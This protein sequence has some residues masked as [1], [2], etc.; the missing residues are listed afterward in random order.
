MAL[1]R[2][3]TLTINKKSSVLNK[4]LTISTNDKGIDIIFRLIDC[5][6]V[7][8]SLKKNLYA[9]IILLDPLGK[10]ID[11]DVTSIVENRVLFRLT[12][13]LMS[14]ITEA[15]IYKLYIAIMD[16]KNNVNLLPPVKCTIEESEVTVRGL[17][18]GMTNQSSIDNS[19]STDYGNEIALFNADGTYNRTVWISGDMITTAR[20]NKLEDA[21][22]KAR[23][24]IL[25]IR[26]EIEE[27]D[28][29]RVH[30]VLIGTENENIVISNLPKGF[31]SIS[32]YVRDFIGKD[33][34][35]LDG[36]NYFIVTYMSDEYSKIQRC[37]VKEQKFI[38]YKYDKILETITIN[39]HELVKCEQND[40]YISLSSDENQYCELKVDSEIILPKV[41]DF[42]KINLFIRAVESSVLI[43]DKVTWINS[44]KLRLG[45]LNLITL[46]Y[47]NGTWYGEARTYLDGGYAHIASGSSSSGG[48]SS[49]SNL[50]RKT[51]PVANNSVVLSDVPIQDVTLV[52][53]CVVD[54]PTNYLATHVTLNVLAIN[55]LR[56]SFVQGSNSQIVDLEKDS[57]TK[58]E[59][60]MNGTDSTICRINGGGNP[61]SEEVVKYTIINN[62]SNCVSNNTS[63]NINRGSS[64]KAIITMDSGYELNN[65][66]I[67]MG[68]TNVTT[69]VY[70]YRDS[71]A[72]I[73]ISKVTGDIIVI[74]QATAS[75]EGDYPGEAFYTVTKNLTN[76]SSSNTSSSVTEGASY[77]TS[78]TAYSGCTLGSI[79]VSMNG[80]DITSTVVNGNSINIPNVTGDLVITA[81]AK[82]KIALSRISDMTIY[83]G[84]TF[85]ILYSSNISAVKHEISWDGGDTF[86]DKTSEILVEN[87]VNYKYSHNAETEYDS[88]NMAIR[89]TDAN[90]N[91]DVK[92]FTI[93][94]VN[95]ELEPGETTYTITRNLTNC[96]SSNTSTSV[97]KGSSY[98]T[99]IMA[100]DNSTMDSI[101]VLMKGVD[102]ANGYATP[103]Y[104]KATY[105]ISKNLTNCGSSNTSTSVTEGSGYISKITANNGYTLSSIKVTM[106]GNDVTSSVV[107][108][109]NINIANVTGNIVITAKAESSGFIF[110][111]YKRLDDGVLVDYTDESE[112]TYYATVGMN[113]VEPASNYAIDVNLCSYICVCYYDEYKNYI[114]YTES[115]TDDWSVKQLSTTILTPS[116]AKYIRVCA[117]NS[118]TQVVG[119]LTK[120]INSGFVF[121]KYKRLNDGVLVDYTD[122]SEVT[123][124]ATVN[125]N[126]VMPGSNYI[127]SINT[128][129]YICVCYY[130]ENHNYLTYTEANTDDWSARQFS[131]TIT[132]PSNARYIRV[133]ATNYGTQV[134]GT[135]IKID[136]IGGFTF[137]KYKR[138][139]DGVLIDYTDESE[140]TYHATVNLNEVTP[141]ANYIIKINSC[142]YIY[143]CYYDEKHNYISYTEAHTD[144]WSI[145]QL[146]TTI[147]IPSNAKYIRVCATNNGAQVEGV[148]TQIINGGGVSIEEI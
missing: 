143:V 59:I 72:I 104:G 75:S 127:I 110:T 118:G 71:K 42:T 33:P 85:N 130:D 29:N 47:M 8:L 114:T 16:D 122:E 87:T 137:T 145:K 97:S 135:L 5:P 138:L 109:N 82:P 123:Y 92:Y 108:G 61:E 36:E 86:W 88:F 50:F 68:G 133:C 125:L 142:N 79:T 101:S 126:P 121:T 48:S 95:N 37:L 11:S 40:K 103:I 67:T 117:T 69:S 136:E 65:I 96:S 46:T 18:V 1:K 98:T 21:A 43:F 139:N 30:K 31:Y 115:N 83:K 55:N 120:T 10:Q 90:G 20:M 56:L 106:G 24:S 57:L 76:C 119:T 128:C 94:F 91:T 38:K 89:V 116:N 147:T 26:D 4:N 3:Y 45:E 14:K 105:T 35:K 62:L 25:S 73:N 12:K 34:Y 58:F 140:A 100:N 22:S 77:T 15:G 80:N 84:Q 17:S 39:E 124:Y 99:N 74:A 23:D 66:E 134:T 52:Q 60:I 7:S 9:R 54:I 49:Q 148:L 102:V 131:T 63:T 81:T 113:P 64:Y 93:T 78:I 28:S 132:I 111:K 144:N 2:E 107:D 27:L 141:N 53:N 112:A 70:T 19:L 32:G 146:L 51:L 6:Y 13:N 129:T 44:P 41:Y